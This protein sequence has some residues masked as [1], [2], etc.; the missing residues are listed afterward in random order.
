[1]LGLLAGAGLALVRDWRDQRVRSADEITAMLGVPVL[2]AMP[3]I[4]RRSLTARSQLLA[5]PNSGDAEAYRVIRTAL[6]FGV[7]RD[8]ARTVLV[9]SPAPLEGKTT[10]VTNLGIAMA[11]AGQKTLILDADL[12]RPMQHRAFAMNGHNKGLSEVLDGTATLEEAIRHTV[13]PGL[14]VLA[15]KHAVENPSELLSS[16]ALRRS[17]G[18]DHAKV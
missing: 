5:A 3:S 10:L 12:R 16:S 2:G 6:F 1:M 11:R 9:T 14:D 8:E 4:P 18:R 7:P 17:A 15:S 13:V